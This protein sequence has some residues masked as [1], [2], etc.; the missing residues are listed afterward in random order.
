M[1][2]RLARRVTPATEDRVC[3][4]RETQLTRDNFRMSSVTTPTRISWKGVDIKAALL[5][6][7]IAGAVDQLLLVSGIMLGGGGFWDATRLT[8]AI[9]L[10]QGVLPPPSTFNATVVVVATVVHF[11]LALIYGFIIA[12][13]VRKADWATGVMIGVA[14]GFVI[15]LFNFYLVAPV[16]FPWWV[17]TRGLVAT[18]IHPVFGLTAAAAYLRLRADGNRRKS[19]R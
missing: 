18:L 4:N 19:L 2:K 7:L 16:L 3:C 9:A 6:G 15:Y 17:G 11:G 14:A 1:I 5:A 10:G 8:A 12:W 13:L